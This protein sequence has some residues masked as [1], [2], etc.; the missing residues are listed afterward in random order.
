MFASYSF[1]TI[2]VLAL[3]L[4]LLALVGV[5]DATRTRILLAGIL[6]SGAAVLLIAKIYPELTA[7][8][9]LSFQG[10]AVP[11]ASLVSLAERLSL[12]HDHR[13]LQSL[14]LQELP[15]MFGAPV[16]LFMAR[17]YDV[18]VSQI[19]GAEGDCDGADIRLPI[20][21]TL[22]QT[23]FASE[24]SLLVDPIRKG[25]LHDFHREDEQRLLTR[26]DL[27]LLAPLR[28]GGALQGIIGL[29]AKVSEDAWSAEDLTALSMLGWV[30]GAALQNLWL[31]D[32]VE[33][34][35]QGL[36]RAHRQSLMEQDRQQRE[37]AQSLHD[38]P[39]QQLL[40][41]G[42]QLATLQGTERQSTAAG[43]IR[44]EVLVAIDQLRDAIGILRPPGLLELGL[45]AALR[46][47]VAR[48]QRAA[49]DGRPCLLLRL[50]A[51]E[52]HL[53]SEVSICLFRCVQEALRNALRHAQASLVVIGL[54]I[55][56]EQVHLIVRDDGCGFKA[57]RYLSELAQANH[58]GL[59]GLAERVEWLGGVLEIQS[60]PGE[61]TLISVTLPVSLAE[62]GG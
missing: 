58:F 49:P 43:A 7:L 21:C 35:K 39:V 38:G 30:A 53:P 33:S 22:A 23:V 1:V 36:A 34:A 27:E 62:Q 4:G 20:S 11:E 9:R 10:R 42:Y 57:P 29:G 61:G 47:Y 52:A 32:E 40:G 24:R 55:E 28:A 15:R 46:D 26:A 2:I 3:Y 48:M 14:L 8:T 45:A 51:C 6:V 41:V 18:L 17:R 13:T 19:C 12:A 44:T 56:D 54:R 16:I 31:L 50:A 5:S 37:L 59:L 25:H 60:R